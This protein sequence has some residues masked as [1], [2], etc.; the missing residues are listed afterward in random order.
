MTALVSDL[1]HNVLV[2]S[3]WEKVSLKPEFSIYPNPNSGLLNIRSNESS[4]VRIISITGKEVLKFEMQAGRKQVDF[5][6]FE[7]GVYFLE[8]SNSKGRIVRKVLRD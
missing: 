7:K 2:L 1:M 4:M 3:N 5:Q 6:L 8:F